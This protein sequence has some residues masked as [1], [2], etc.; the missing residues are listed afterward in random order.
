MGFV[1]RESVKYLDCPPKLTPH[2]QVLG[3]D[4]GHPPY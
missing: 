3:S 2:Q 4:L 1:G